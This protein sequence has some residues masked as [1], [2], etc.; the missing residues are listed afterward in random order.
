MLHR[1]GTPRRCTHGVGRDERAAGGA[2]WRAGRRAGEVRGQPA[3]RERQAER[4]ERAERG[5]R[6]HRQQLQRG[7]R[8]GAAR[9]RRT[10]RAPLEDGR[11]MRTHLEPGRAPCT[12]GA[13]QQRA[14]ATR[15][16]ISIVARF[17]LEQRQNDPSTA[18]GLA[19][20]M[21]RVGTNTEHPRV[22]QPEQTHRKQPAISCL[23]RVHF[24][25]LQRPTAAAASAVWSCPPATCTPPLRKAMWRPPLCYGTACAF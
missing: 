2:D 17:R 14:P 23:L 21:R 9:T 4:A 8:R 25:L 15:T 11:R 7:V 16:S 22:I 3:G 10:E 13:H 1:G 20:L 5:G 6:R 19:C 12:R 24:S 18:D